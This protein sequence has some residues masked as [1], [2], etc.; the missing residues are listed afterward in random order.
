MSKFKHGDKVVCV[1]ESKARGVVLGGR[2]TINN[3][4]WCPQVGCHTRVELLE[5]PDASPLESRFELAIQDE[6]VA[7]FA[8]LPTHKVLSYFLKGTENELEYLATSGA[9]TEAFCSMSFS[10]IKKL[11]FR[12]K[13]KVETIDY[14]GTALPKPLVLDDLKDTDIVYAVQMLS[15]GSVLEGTAR[16]SK[17]HPEHLLTYRTR[18]EAQ[19]VFDT[20]YK[21]FL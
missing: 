1:Q 16:F 19:L 15:S 4:D 10:S 14:Y 11:V 3:P 18:E 5:L 7:E 17:R 21:P 6:P 9:W 8:V 13:P 20:M 2:Y 12:V